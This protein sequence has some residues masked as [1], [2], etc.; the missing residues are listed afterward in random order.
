MHTNRTTNCETNNKIN[1]TIKKKT[2]ETNH[3]HFTAHKPRTFHTRETKTNQSRYLH[4]CSLE[5]AVKTRSYRIHTKKRGKSGSGILRN[6]QSH[7]NDKPKD[8][9]TFFYPVDHYVVN[10]E[11]GVSFATSR[12]HSEWWNDSRGNPPSKIRNVVWR[13][14]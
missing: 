6:T 1:I 10:N 11:V 2:T 9:S 14:G 8:F 12:P 3:P 7:P 13:S 4:K 5:Y